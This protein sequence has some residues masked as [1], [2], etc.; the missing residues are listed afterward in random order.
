ML[1]L[2]WFEFLF[3]SIPESYFIVLAVHAFSKQTINRKRYLLAG[4]ADAVMVFAVRELPISYGIYHT[5]I[6][7]ILL[8]IIVHYINQ[9]KVRDCIRSSI[10]TFVIL[11]IC[12]LLDIFIMQ[13]FL[14]LDV[15]TVFGNVYLKTLS[16]LPSLMLFILISILSYYVLV[17]RKRK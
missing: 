7:I 10:I 2:T 14:H 3:R 1:H 8:N 16:G 13:N 11:Y 6:I 15:E 17:I 9:I 5:A 4:L 12:E